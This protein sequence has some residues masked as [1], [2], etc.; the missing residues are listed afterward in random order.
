MQV[1]VGEKARATPP[2]EN[3]P[4][5]DSTGGKPISRA[6]HKL[7]ANV[8]ALG[9]RQRLVARTLPMPYASSSSCFCQRV[10]TASLGMRRSPRGLTATLPT[11]GPSGRQLR[12]NCWEKKR[13]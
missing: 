13:Q 10:Q 1:L 5:S 3:A 12:L 6:N 2:A 7:Q 11:L 8:A 4:G 9:R